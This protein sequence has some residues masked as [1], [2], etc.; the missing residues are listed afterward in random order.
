MV[1][2]PRLPS[3]LVLVFFVGTR[4]SGTTVSAAQVLY[5]RFNQS[6]GAT[7]IPDLSGNGY[8]GTLP[9]GGTFNG[10]YL[11]LDSTQSQ[12]VQISSAL[13]PS[14]NTVDY[15]ISSCIVSKSSAP[16]TRL[17]DFNNGYYSP[18]AL[19]PT[20]GKEYGLCACLSRSVSS[21]THFPST[22]L[23]LLWLLL[24]RPGPTLPWRL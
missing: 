17:F 13:K 22:S 5:Y 10:E 18:S 16:W 11:T 2:L 1:V 23:L 14:L 9:N 21:L 7:T 3:A 6:V 20:G 24:W 4:L 15:T 12:W 19:P 8:D